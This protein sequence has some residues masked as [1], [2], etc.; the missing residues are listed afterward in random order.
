MNYGSKS[1]LTGQDRSDL[2][3]LYESVWNGVLDNV[4]GTPIVLFR[5]FHYAAPQVPEL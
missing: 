4:N 5:P 1:E 2:R 3:N